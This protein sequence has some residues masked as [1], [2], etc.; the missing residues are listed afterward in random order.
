MVKGLDFINNGIQQYEEKQKND[1]LKWL[2]KQA[3][4]LNFSLTP[5]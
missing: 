2:E 1:R 4:E 3:K 5:C